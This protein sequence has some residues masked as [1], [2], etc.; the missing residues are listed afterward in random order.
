MPFLFM[1]RTGSH[2]VFF[3]FFNSAT[4][5]DTMLV[6]LHSVTDVSF[7]FQNREMIAEK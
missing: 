6:D 5:T 3:F 2:R 7:L 4:L 1:M